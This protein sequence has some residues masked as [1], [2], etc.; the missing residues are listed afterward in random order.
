MKRT[1]PA[2]A[3]LLMMFAA[4]CGS[5]NRATPAQ[6]DKAAMEAD[7]R[8]KIAEVDTSKTFAIEVTIDDSR[9]VTLDGHADN[10]AEIDK[11]VAAAKSVN[12]VKHVYSKIHVQ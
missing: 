8:G 3:I 11:I 4:A 10:Q 6:W 5:M 2:L 1:L 7:V 12:G 9:N